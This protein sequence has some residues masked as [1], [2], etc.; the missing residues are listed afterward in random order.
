MVV[1]LIR[2]SFGDNAG[3]LKTNAVDING[4]ESESSRMIMEMTFKTY[5]GGYAAVL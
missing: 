3:S 2:T 5:Q 1:I 4:L